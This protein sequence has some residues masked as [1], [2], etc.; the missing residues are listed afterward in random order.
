[1]REK[2]IP[3][4]LREMNVPHFSEPARAQ[5]RVRQEG[6]P[7][8]AEA[9]RAS[10]LPQR[11]TRARFRLGVILGVLIS[12]LFFLLLQVVPDYLVKE[13]VLKKVESR[14]GHP[15]TAEHLSISLLPRIRLSI[16]N[17]AGH[18]ADFSADDF[19][20]DR[21]DVVVSV[22][23][24]LHGG[25][26]VERLLIDAPR[27][28]VQRD[29]NGQWS[30]PLLASIDRTPVTG[31]G[32]S[33]SPSLPVPV[34]DLQVTKGTINLVDEF[35]RDGA[36]TRA[37][38]GV[39]AGLRVDQSSQRAEVNVS[40]LLPST[41]QLSTINLVGVV[42]PANP[43]EQ[44]ATRL[45]VPWRFS[46]AVQAGGIDM[47]QVAALF[48][49][50]SSAEALPQTAHV[51]A[52]FLL[53]PRELGHE[54]LVPKFTIE[55][56]AIV[57]TGSAHLAG[58][59]TKTT[60]YAVTVASRPVTVSQLL[61]EVPIERIPV[62]WQIRIA[63]DRP[64]GTLTLLD[65][66]VRSRGGA[67]SQP[68]WKA[69]VMLT[70]GALI[71][72][73]GRTP[74]RDLS[75]RI[76]MK[77][78]QVL[79]NEVRATSDGMQVTEGTAV[80]SNVNAS[81]RVDLTAA[82]SAEAQ[83]LIRLLSG[84]W[85]SAGVSEAVSGV[86]EID[87]KLD[88][89]IHAAGPLNDSGIQL[90]KGRVE[91]Q[92]LA[93]R[94]SAFP[95]SVNHLSGRLGIVPGRLDIENLRWRV[96]AV[97]V[98]ASGRIDLVKTARFD[99]V[100]LQ[101]DVD[102]GELAAQVAGGRNGA[103]QTDP[104]GPVRLRTTLSGPLT[105]PRIVG[106]LD[107][108]DV[109]LRMHGLHKQA[110][111]PIAVQFQASL[112]PNK[113]LDV[114]RVDV[115]VP[116]AHVKARGSAHLARQSSFDV[117]IR[118]DPMAVEKL[119]PGIDLGRA[120][121]GT[122]SASLHVT[123]TGQDWSASSIDGWMKLDGGTVK[124]AQV[125]YPL[126]DLAIDLTFNKN[127]VRIPHAHMSMGDS[128]V[129]ASGSITRWREAPRVELEIVSPSLNL[130]L[131][132]S[133]MRSPD[134]EMVN[135]SPSWLQAAI[136]NAS[137]K[138]ERMQYQQLVLTD[139]TGR[140]SATEGRVRLDGITAHTKEGIFAGQFTGRWP[141]GLAPTI[142]GYLKVTGVPVG[143]VLGLVAEENRL[144]GWLSV[145]GGM[146][147]EEAGPQFEKSLTSLTDI[148]VLIEEGRINQS[149]VIARMLKLVNL[150]ALVADGADVDRDG[151]PFRR[152]SGLF[153]VDQGLV[154]V[155]E[156]YLD[157]PLLKISGAGS[158]DAVADRLDLAMALNPLQS[159]S[160][161][162]GKIPLIGRLLSG[163]R[164][165]LGA[166]LYEVTGPLKDPHVRIL[167]AESLEGGVSGFARLAY[168]ILVNAAKLPADLLT[169]PQQVL[170]PDSQ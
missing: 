145:D 109:E 52:D 62:Q 20:A 117:T 63:E 16:V 97:P 33:D 41:S 88:L 136:M 12:V 42:T 26:V 6:S 74:I 164:E 35:K 149:P 101:I 120:T 23:S 45:A 93:F 31:T 86:G 7:D 60:S 157:S 61:D 65:A 100:E 158:Y 73:S 64:R 131:F 154:K 8:P 122:V 11:R 78:E 85:P 77:P 116:P 105:A 124:L 1:M 29:E 10:Q 147:A 83:S 15:I 90:I 165:G 50:A 125:K 14:L 4:T 80:I 106:L 75:A 3:R 56:G 162:L 44:A 139:V 68:E 66:T 132:S 167:P 155:K 111:T 129:R 22:S 169:R 99:D 19:H 71:V 28:V 25:T 170:E 126:R 102:A 89:W 138:I 110:G 163:K 108:Q 2:R 18:P 58:L 127:V 67:S 21:I 40:A 55:S 140:V 17:V 130:D 36:K 84:L 38:T 144:N 133:K 87:G 161:W 27:I 121:A 72:G 53:D 9:T 104:S 107:L 54:L 118:L 57:L 137:M 96:G 151:I 13:L 37:L 39:Q 24:W 143:D 91:V 159:Y 92:D 160:T 98:E 112:S 135:E 95:L 115:T 82:G 47:R 166:T 148:Q 79:V 49:P 119:P 156:L 150:P 94:V 43:A 128:S 113:V 114:Q 46:G 153:V 168:D 34:M 5:Q 48:L 70:N 81:P 142:E 30:I 152:L 69:E 146:R 51:A 134:E 32:V 76:T 103:F 59:G 141:H 123:G